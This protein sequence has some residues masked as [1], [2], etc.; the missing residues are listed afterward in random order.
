MKTEES[1]APEPSATT[2]PG[3]TVLDAATVKRYIDADRPACLDAVRTAYT[4]HHAGH[5]VNPPSSFLRFPTRERE[6]IIA[7]PAHL[8]GG[9]PTSGIKWI[10]SFPS[11]TERGIPRAS[12][13]LVL[14]DEDTGYPTTVMEASLISATRTAASAVL[15][16]ELLVGQ[17]RARRVGFI[18][19]GLIADNVLAFL[20]E[21]HWTV[22]EFVLCD[23]TPS[24]AQRFSN[25]VNRR[26][27]DAVVHVEQAEQ[28]VRSSDLLVVTT[29][30][31]TPHI[32]EPA[33][34]AHNPV[35]LHLSLRD[36]GP[37]VI[38]TAFNVT[39]DVDHAV[40]EGTSLQLAA[41]QQP[42]LRF[43]DGTIGEL[44]EGSITRDPSRPAIF[45]PFGLGVLDMALG[46]W[47]LDESHG[48]DGTHLNDFYAG[49]TEAS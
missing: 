6:R 3:L 19:T 35:V 14:N 39:D 4:T 31:G 37:Q 25:R 8:G 20:D 10:S 17:K 32:V 46:R 38:R 16:A 26:F 40:R 23:T 48:H 33:W 36:L 45:S 1:V 15:G 12:A 22:D 24:H 27:P 30:A 41:E 13:L 18:G 2:L 21:T 5:S 49:L 44:I 47:V 28:T 29:T 42:D 11:N 9:K 43:I 7:L 34:F